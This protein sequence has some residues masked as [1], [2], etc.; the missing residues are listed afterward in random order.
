M[1]VAIGPGLPVPLSVT[2]IYPSFY[3]NLFQQ[4]DVG[5]DGK[6]FLM[7]QGVLKRRG[8]STV[9]VKVNWAA[10]TQP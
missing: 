10:K 8:V 7:L 2:G 3:T 6:R 4:Y 9:M 1:P 5:A